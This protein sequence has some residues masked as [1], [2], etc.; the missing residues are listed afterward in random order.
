M[1]L[2]LGRAAAVCLLALACTLLS[3]FSTRTTFVAVEPCSP[4]ATCAAPVQEAGWPLPWIRTRTA[5]SPAEPLEV[6]WAAI[7]ADMA[8]YSLLIVLIGYARRV[9]RRQTRRPNR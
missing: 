8:F 5:L 7:P 3:Q 4:G 9:A 1:N 2:R 6:L